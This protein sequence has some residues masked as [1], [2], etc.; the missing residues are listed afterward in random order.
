MGTYIYTIRKE[1]VEATLL[2]E[3]KKVTVALAKYACKDS[4]SIF[5]EYDPYYKEYS[6]IRAML[7]RAKRMVAKGFVPD[8]YTENFRSGT[9]YMFHGIAYFGDTPSLGHI[10]G[11]MVYTNKKYFI[12]PYDKKISDFNY[13]I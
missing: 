5:N 6:N 2:P 8:F 9:A 7:S 1:T 10:K 3:N 13:N 4:D 11:K 12:I